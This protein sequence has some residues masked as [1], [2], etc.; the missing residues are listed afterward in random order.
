MTLEYVFGEADAEY[1]IN[2]ETTQEIYPVAY[3]TR[4]IL[5]ILSKVSTITPK[6]AAE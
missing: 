5:N 3:F 2:L 1:G 6:P 4:D